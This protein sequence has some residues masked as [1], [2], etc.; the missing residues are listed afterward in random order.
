MV[1]TQ[2]QNGTVDKVK[3]HLQG[4]LSNN[5]YFLALPEHQQ[6]KLYKD[7]LASGLD[8]AMSG[9]LDR[10]LDD[11][12]ADLKP[13]RMGD[14]GA[15][16]GGFIQDVDFPTFVKDLITGV[17]ESIVKSTIEQMN[18]YLEMYKGL[19]KPLGAIAKEISE[20]DALA[21]VA[22]NDPLK[23]TMTSNGDLM[24]NTTNTTL[25]RSDEQVQ[26]LMYQAK[27][28]LAKERRLL[29]R[30][31]MLMG[32]QRLVVQR[33][34]IR[35]TVD[36]NATATE[37]SKGQGSKTDITESGG[38][39]GY[40]FFG[41]F[42]GGGADKKTSISVNTRKLDTTA[43]LQAQMTGFVEVIFASDYFKLDNFATL[44]GDE[45][46]K[47]FV[48]ERRAQLAPAGTTPAAP[49]G[50]PAAVTAPLPAAPPVGVAGPVR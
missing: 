4:F 30:E 26:R 3:K 16:A 45:G 17:Y 8:A 39:T 36:F 18:A 38:Q 11:P 7:L 35:A 48:D 22:S 9:V 13:T 19:A 6:L 47:A 2:T 46:T 15:M 24:D 25:D 27:L 42:G 40:S 28:A 43:S 10:A 29:L 34:T 5:E 31:T 37:K 23:Y 1:N 50:A 44:F 20:T 33:G 12:N 14:I 41:L 32:V 49:A 21:E